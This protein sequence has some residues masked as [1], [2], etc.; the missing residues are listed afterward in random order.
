M[1]VRPLLHD[2]IS[3]SKIILEGDKKIINFS[4]IQST[5][6]TTDFYTVASR[7]IAYKFSEP[8]SSTSE[9]LETQYISEY[10]KCKGFQG[11]KFHSSL[12]ERGNNIVLFDYSDC[13]PICSFPYKIDEI[14]FTA[15]C[16]FPMG[17]FDNQELIVTNKKIPHN[18]VHKKE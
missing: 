4:K 15:R 6:E 10:I 3:V 16:T 1:E 7:Y 2:L 5:D 9:Y 14:T 18:P 17:N 8:V 13:K 12:N 11:I